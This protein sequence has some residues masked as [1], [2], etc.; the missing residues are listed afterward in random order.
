MVNKTEAL[1]YVSSLAEHNIVTKNELSMAFDAGSKKKT[2][3]ISAKKFGMTE[4][5]Y[6][7]GGGVV[8]LGI[9]I[10]LQQHWS[11]LGF[12][13]K[14]LATLGSGLA[15]YVVGLL[16]DRDERTLMASVA[17]FLIF[18]LVTPIG[19]WVMLDHAGFNA[20]GYGSQSIIS[21]IMLMGCLS[22]LLVFRKIIFTLFSILFATWLFFSVT[23]Y[24]VAD[25]VYFSAGAFYKYR[26]L[27]VGV[28]YG[29]LGRAFSQLGHKSLSGLLYNFGILGFLSAALALGGWGAHRNVFWELVYPILV[30]AALFLS[31]QVKSKAVLVWSALFLMGYIFKITSEYFSASL[32]WP[33]ALVIAGFA[34]MAA[35]FLL[36]SI[37]R[38]CFIVE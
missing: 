4:V 22:S 36:I 18:V 29:F 1:Q 10:L 32:G 12:L 31:V 30:F 3:D 26:I 35:G 19:F 14:I 17:F 37:K 25:G 11:T 38:K 34:M 33:F 9:V 21:G 20:D 27:M 6:Y 5:L 16:F 15:A 8:F 13:T 23:S 7:F 2:G 28:A 24:M